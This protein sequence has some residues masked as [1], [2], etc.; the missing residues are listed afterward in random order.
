MK[1]KFVLI[2][3]ALLIVTIATVVISAQD[4]DYTAVTGVAT[5]EGID[6]P[7]E[8]PAGLVNL[9]FEN[10][11]SEGEFT[12]GIARINDGVTMEQF[13]EAA[14]AE[15]P[16]EA[17]SMVSLYGGTGVLPGES[18][19]YTV[20]LAGGNYLLLEFGEEGPSDFTM[21]TVTEND[22]EPMAAPQADVNL[23]LIDFGFGVPGF[24]SAGEKTWHV[25]NVG[26]QWHE[27]AMIPLPEGISSVADARAAMEAPDQPDIQP[28]LFWAPMSPGTEAWITLDL[29]PG[30]YL[31]LCFLPDLNG[32]FSPHMAH[33]MM[34][35][36]TVE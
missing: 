14:A 1:A 26:D 34:Q 30:N 33:G 36:F 10:N 11:R 32:D 21:F 22:M 24:I 25:E 27:I 4:S 5:D 29:E 28:I 2:V 31:L 12:A 3:I 16:M 9:T 20:D 19:T 13:M 23:A 35:V 8:V 17:V 7:E 6:F 18:I 15:N